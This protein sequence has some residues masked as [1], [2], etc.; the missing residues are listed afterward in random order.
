MAS[1]NINPNGLAIVETLLAHEGEVRAFAEIAHEAHI[2]SRTGFLTAAKKIAET[3][4]YS[5]EKVV[6]GVTVTVKTVSTYPNG[7][8]VENEKTVTLDGYRIVK[9]AKVAE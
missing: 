4:G 9:V 2:E 6:D 5:V 1:K 8:E 3:R 7:L